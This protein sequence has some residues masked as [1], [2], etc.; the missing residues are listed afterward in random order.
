[1]PLK[2]RD[3]IPEILRASMERHPACRALL[4]HFWSFRC[5]CRNEHLGFVNAMHETYGKSGLLQVVGVLIP[6]GAGGADVREYGV[7][8]PVLIDSGRSVAEAFR[9]D[10]LPSCYVFD[11]EG[12]LRH[13]QAGVRSS[14]LLEQTIRKLIR[15]SGGVIQ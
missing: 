8:H 5:S 6:D 1:M 4:V 7:R 11:A 13:Y 2:L 12:K 3:E 9:N 15:T 14:A 10:I